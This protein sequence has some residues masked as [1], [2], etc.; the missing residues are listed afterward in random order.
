MLIGEGLEELK[1]LLK[2]LDS[3][4]RRNLMKVNEKKSKIV[5]FH[6]GAGTEGETRRIKKKRGRRPKKMDMGD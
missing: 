4:T 1:E 6:E 2:R 3:W 5:V